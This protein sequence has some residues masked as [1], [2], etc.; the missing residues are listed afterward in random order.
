MKERNRDTDGCR[1]DLNNCDDNGRLEGVSVRGGVPGNPT[2]DV[3]GVTSEND[4]F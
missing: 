1:Y 3:D 2:E 4:S